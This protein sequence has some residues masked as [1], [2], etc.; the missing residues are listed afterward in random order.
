MDPLGDTETMDATEEKRRYFRHQKAVKIHYSSREGDAGSGYADGRD[1]SR[2]GIRF[3]TACYLA[4]DT[5]LDVKIYLDSTRLELATANVVWVNRV[6]PDV[7]YDV[8]LE[9]GQL[10]STDYRSLVGVLTG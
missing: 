2:T 4:I 8:G 3:S 7:G 10:P 9:F 6:D 5:T 1:V